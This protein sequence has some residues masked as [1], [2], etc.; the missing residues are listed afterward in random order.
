MRLL[1]LAALVVAACNKDGLPASIVQPDLAL[2]PADL[3]LAP[4]GP[5]CPAQPCHAGGF[6]VQM[7]GD[8][9]PD[10]G[11]Q[12][13]SCYYLPNCVGVTDVCSCVRGGP[14]SLC[15][16]AAFCSGDATGIIDCVY[17]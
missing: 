13:P 12:E 1:L 11:Y 8:V 2:D 6:C 3:A 15:E 9:S 5:P 10:G 14:G 7:S 17:W 16:G 4:A